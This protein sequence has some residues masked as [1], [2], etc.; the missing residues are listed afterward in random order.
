ME[1]TSTP[2]SSGGFEAALERAAGAESPAAQPE[3]SPVASAGA[4]VPSADPGSTG[5][6]FGPVPYER[7]SEVNRERTA[8]KEHLERLRWAEQFQPD[9]V[10]HAFTLVQRQAA[11]PVAYAE[12]LIAELH[13]HP[14]QGPR[15]RSLIGKLLAA[16][17]GS[18]Q[19][20]ADPEPDFV[21]QGTGE[22]FYSAKQLQALREAD[23]K[24]VEAAIDSRLKPIETERQQVQQQK[25]YETFT[26]SLEGDAKRQYAEVKDLP[27]FTEHKAAIKQALQDHPEFQTLHQAYL[28][29]FKTAIYPTLG[30]KEQAKAMATLQQKAGAATVNPAS[31]STAVSKSPKSMEE[32]LERAYAAA[33][34]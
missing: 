8:F 31:A 6:T 14:E 13:A 28:H 4:S 25:A 32:A 23:R 10:Q 18:A 19:A 24:R 15:V 22:R 34:R 33:G 21:D 20:S 9:Q 11:D 30:Q 27:G 26:A 3:A 17:R 7:F 5:Q 1:D 2:V 12:Q 16:Q 29:V